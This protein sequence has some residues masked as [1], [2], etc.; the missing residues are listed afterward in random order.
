MLKILRNALCKM[1]LEW[2]LKI[3]IS[4]T[5]ALEQTCVMQNP[6]QPMMNCE[7]R[8]K[9]RKFLTPSCRSQK[10]LILWWE[11]VVTAC[12]VEKNSVLPLRVFS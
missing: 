8:A 6:M 9:V 2:F 4:F 11:N 10:G 12:L 7:Q 1:Q 5:K 3:R